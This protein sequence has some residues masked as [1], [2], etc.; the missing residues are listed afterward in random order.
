MSTGR[1]GRDRCR[2]GSG[3]SRRTPSQHLERLLDAEPL[4]RQKA[5]RKGGRTTEADL[6]TKA[7]AGVSPEAVGDRHAAAR[8]ELALAVEGSSPSA[9]HRARAAHAVRARVETVISRRVRIDPLCRGTR[10]AAQK[11]EC[12]ERGTEEADHV[13]IVACPGASVVPAPAPRASG[14]PPATGTACPR[15]PLALQRAGRLGIDAGTT[16]RSRPSPSRCW[17]SRT[18]HLAADRDGVR[19]RRAGVVHDAT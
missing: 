19:P 10:R 17:A 11:Y 14:P 15:R 8:L 16:A 1:P 4:A 3:P 6:R 9:E 18:K 12:N 5:L 2:S 13:D 7:G